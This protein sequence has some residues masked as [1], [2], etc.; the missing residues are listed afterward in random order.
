MTKMS[1]QLKATV[2]M[3]G[4]N[5]FWG[6]SY[7][8]MKMGL[9]SLGAFNI[10]AL[11]CLIA[12]FIAGILFRKQVV[13][14]NIKTLTSSFVLGVL[15]FSVFTLVTFGVSM[16]SASKAGFLLSLTVVF[17]PLLHSLL[18]RSLPSWT[19]G[20]GVMITLTGIGVLTLKSSLTIHLGDLLCI[21]SALSYAVHILFTGW[22][23]K[24]GNPITLGVLQLGFAGTIALVCSMLFEQPS[25]PATSDAWI[26]ILGLGIFCSAIGFICQ[27]IAQQHTSPTHTGLIFATEPI[28]AALFAVLFWGE[29]FTSRDFAGSSLILCGILLAQ[30]DQKRLF[31]A[32]FAHRF[33]Y[34]QSETK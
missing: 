31:N 19:V 4:V 30:L 12:F 18:K 25:L 7:V 15:L 27:A 9:G 8:F 13:N 21:G 28:F 14:I 16:T 17:V 23:A 20:T 24:E 11:R 32:K 29:S 3:I 22:A 10:I 26:A 5:M 33:F 6:L 34:R 1:I 2:M